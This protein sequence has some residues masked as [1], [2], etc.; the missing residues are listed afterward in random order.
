MPDDPQSI[1]DVAQEINHLIVDLWLATER[2]GPRYDQ[3]DLTGQQHS[4]LGLIVTRPDLTPGDL[5]HELGVT[6]G[7]ISQHLAHL[8]QDGYIAR[9]RA[10]HD[11]R[12]HVLRLQKRGE[13]YRRTLQRSEDSLAAAY[14]AHLTDGDLAEIATALTKLKNA[15]SS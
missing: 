12:V 13:A 3:F 15:V 11:R 6:K 5:A 4:V 10:E 9:E 14:R 1:K 8:E 7:A 2:R